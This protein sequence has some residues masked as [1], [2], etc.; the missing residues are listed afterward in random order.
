MIP[1]QQNYSI[2]GPSI[3]GY[4]NIQQNF[5]PVQGFNNNPSFLPQSSGQEHSLHQG[6]DPTSPELFKQNLQL[7]QQSVLQLQEVAKRALDGIQNA[8]RTGRT[9]TQTDADLATLKQ[10]LQMVLEQM[11][12]TGVGGLPLLPVSDGN[13]PPPALPTEDQ[14]IAQ[15]TRAIQVLYDQFKRGQDSAAVVANLLTSVDRPPVHR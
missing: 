12:Q 10:T 1:T 2:S 8:Y 7:A 4:P 9:P 13:Q 6:A 15:T 11:R 5:S 14:M 3:T